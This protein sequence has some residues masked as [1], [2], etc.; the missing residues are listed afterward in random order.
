MDKAEM[1]TEL[2]H[3]VLTQRWH[4]Y[5]FVADNAQKLDVWFEFFLTNPREELGH[6]VDSYKK[7]YKKDLGHE[8]DRLAHQKLVEK[9]IVDILK[10]RMDHSREEEA[11]IQVY[12]IKIGSNK[13]ISFLFK[14]KK[15]EPINPN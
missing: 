13:F 6:L 4:K 9:S 5:L 1:L 2:L 3:N 14:M 11:K 8:L 15:W 12:R 10:E 7:I